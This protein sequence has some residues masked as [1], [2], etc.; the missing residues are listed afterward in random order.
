[1]QIVGEREQFPIRPKDIDISNP[2]LSVFGMWEAEELA[3]ELIRSC[4]RYD[5]WLPIPLWLAPF[6]EEEL[7]KTPLYYQHWVELKDGHLWFTEEFVRK[8]YYRG[9]SYRGEQKEENK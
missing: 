8:C 7:K 4:Q 3:A 1:M 2:L 9:L 6:D 5:S